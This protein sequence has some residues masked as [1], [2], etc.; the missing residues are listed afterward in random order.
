MLIHWYLMGKAIV[1]II[2]VMERGARQK[3]NVGWHVEDFRIKLRCC[4]YEPLTLGVLSS[5]Q[6]L[7]IK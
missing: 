5:I 2:Q 4:F 7:I 3:Y 6:I 1:A